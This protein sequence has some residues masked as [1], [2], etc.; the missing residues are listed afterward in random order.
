MNAPKKSSK[1]ILSLILAFFVF[2]LIKPIFDMEAFGK[3]ESYYY[4]HYSL[5]TAASDTFKIFMHMPLSQFFYFIAN[6]YNILLSRSF[7]LFAL[8]IISFFSYKIS[9]SIGCGFNRIILFFALALTF[10]FYNYSADVEQIFFSAY[11]LLFL[12][13]FLERE[14]NFL[15]FFW[16]YFSIVD[17]FSTLFY[18]WK[19]DVTFRYWRGW[20]PLKSLEVMVENSMS[21]LIG[22]M[23]RSLVILTGLIV[24]ALFSLLSFLLILIWLAP[25]LILFILLEIHDMTIQEMN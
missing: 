19:K 15:G 10:Y 25:P 12:I 2:Y 24:I 20:K 18:P 23:A 1:A 22:A 3:F 9:D 21:R 17:L 11:I 7:V 6:H 8:W 14:K 13:L 5:S 16:R 4:I